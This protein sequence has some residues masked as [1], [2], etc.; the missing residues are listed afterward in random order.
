[1]QRIAIV[2]AGKIGS[3]IAAMLS[4]SGSYDVTVLDRDQSQLD[5]LRIAHPVTRLQVDIDDAPALSAA[6]AG[7][8]AV[9]NAGPFQLTT[10]IAGAA[11]SVGAHYLDLTEDVASTRIVRGLAEGAEAA[12]IPVRAADNAGASSMSTC[13]RVTGWAMRRRSSWL[14]SRS[15]TVTS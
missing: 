14:W 12:F 5:R 9:L 15:S 3:M 1:M 7:M 11:R 13:R 6:L 8:K 2:G 10:R 4:G